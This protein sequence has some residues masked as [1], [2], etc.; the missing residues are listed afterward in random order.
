MRA[1][2]LL[3]ALLAASV[4]TAEERI[5]SYH[6]DI[7]VLP[8]SA[9]EVVETIRVRAEGQRIRRGIYRDFPTVYQDRSG[10][11]VVTGFEL[12]ELTR[13][14]RPEPHH[15][16]QR[17]NGVRLYA[18]DPEIFLQPGEY[19][20]RISYRS[21]RQLGLY[22]D[23][24]ELYWNVTGNGWDLPIDQASASVVLPPGVPSP[25]IGVEAYTGP[26]GARGRDWVA[27]V[28]DGVPR[29]AT[30]QALAAREGLTIVATW[31]KG[32]VAPPGSVARLGYLSRDAW[33]ALA[34]GLGLFALVGYYL[35]AW[36]R[37]GR[38][39]PG[40]APAPIYEMPQGQSAASIRYLREMGYD[41]RC[42]AAAVLALAVKGWLRIEQ[43]SSGF[44]GRASE[45]VLE[46]SG[47]DGGE[48]PAPDERVLLEKLFSGD[49][50]LELKNENH[51]ILRAAKAAHE[52]SLKTRFM[53]SFFRVNGGWHALGILL[54]LVV[55]GVGVG[56]PLARAAYSVG[57]LFGT[58]PGWFTL[59][60]TV[61]ALLINLPFGRLLK[62]P[63][64]SGRAAMDRIEG[65]RLFLDVAEGDELRLVDAPPLTP[66]LF[67]RNLPAALALGVEQRWAERFA[68]VFATLAPEAQPDWYHGD[69]WDSRRLGDFSGS[70][71]DSLEGAISSAS[72]APGS[73]S[74]SG[75]GG[76]S[77]GGG[78]GGGGGGW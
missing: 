36:N 60:A 15:S 45:F 33:P 44:L 72:T 6:S 8:D 9:I 48:A 39:P 31:P 10:R 42:F 27:S 78:G 23:H 65:Y 57:W 35:F 77:G 75:G 74:G 12:L 58:R 38:D 17:A 34:A 73:S 25:S 24:D 46:R 29:F 43:T 3:L 14:G 64:V 13:D 22:A 11:R 54:S 47:R 70:F 76:S 40:R 71:G 68:G 52:E 67:E 28:D 21:D 66:R 4:A 26:F 53:P 37:V 63:T 50:R 32:F 61:V 2:Y 7:R 5:L 41:D 51:A 20:Y 56:L 69:R 19:T 1:L 18:G 59:G 62:A 16:E 30:T 55:I 49:S